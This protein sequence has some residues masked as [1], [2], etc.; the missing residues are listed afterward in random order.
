MRF[1]PT[2]DNY[3]LLSRLLHMPHTLALWLYRH[4]EEALL[5][6]RLYINTHSDT[7]CKAIDSLIRYMLKQ[8]FKLTSKE[9]M[10]EVDTDTSQVILKGKKT[11]RGF[12]S[13]LKAGEFGRHFHIT[14][15]AGTVGELVSESPLNSS[16]LVIFTKAL[17]I[18]N[19]LPHTVEAGHSATLNKHYKLVPADDVTL[20]FSPGE[21]E[22]AAQQL[23]RQHG[24]AER[25][26]V[27]AP[28]LVEASA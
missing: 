6:T 21:D 12:L 19:L 28:K 3:I 24:L 13:I 26:A 5:K 1:K 20:S 23:I 17:S 4:P 11:I 15:H 22:P 10:L 18:F 9:I 2:T 25:E 27:R 8:R 7:E 14:L 16:H